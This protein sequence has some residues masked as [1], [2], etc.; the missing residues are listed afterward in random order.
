ML[1]F[2]WMRKACCIFFPLRF[3]C[4]V[5]CQTSSAAISKIKTQICSEASNVVFIPCLFVV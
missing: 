4:V 1:L 3:Y 5:F 2:E